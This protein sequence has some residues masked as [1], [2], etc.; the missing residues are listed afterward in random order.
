MTQKMTEPKDIS[1]DSRSNTITMVSRFSMNQEVWFV[2]GAAIANG[3]ITGVRG[4]VGVYVDLDMEIK[5]RQLYGPAVACDEWMMEKNCFATANECVQTLIS[6]IP[7]GALS[8]PIPEK[9]KTWKPTW[10]G[11]EEYEQLGKSMD[12]KTGVGD[13]CPNCGAP[14]VQH[15]GPQTVYAC[16]SRDLD[17]RP[18]TFMQSELCAKERVD[19]RHFE[20]AMNDLEEEEVDE[21]LRPSHVGSQSLLDFDMTEY[22]PVELPNGCTMY[23]TNTEVG[24]RRYVSDETGGGVVVWDTA[25][26]D[27]TTILAAVMTEMKLNTRG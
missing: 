12:K 11:L 9:P 2:K 18:G 15:N 27:S 23:V 22:E 25:L 19:L 26:V 14:E 3:T 16:G 1:E 8:G 13:C 10:E 5:V 7:D 17:Q 4:R 24:G 20:L 6:S 21:T